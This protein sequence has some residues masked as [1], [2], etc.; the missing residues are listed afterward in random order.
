MALRQVTCTIDGV[1]VTIV[2]DDVAG[3][4]TVS[5]ELDDGFAGDFRG[6]FFKPGVDVGSLTAAGVGVT[7][8]LGDP[9]G[10]QDMGQGANIHGV[11][12]KALEPTFGVEIGGPGNGQGM[13]EA[14]SFVLTSSDGPLTLEDLG[15]QMGIRITGGNAAGKLLCDIPAAP[16]AQDD[17]AYVELADT[18]DI[19]VAAND[20]DADGDLDPTSVAITDPPDFG[21]AVVNPDG[22]VTYADTIVDTAGDDSVVDAFQYQIDDDDGNFGQAD[23]AVNV[24][25]PLREV[26]V[27]DAVTPNGQSISLTVATEDRTANDSSFVEVDIVTGDLVEVDVNVAFVFDASGSISAAEYAEQIEAIQDTIDLLRTQFTGAENDVEVQLIR[28]ATGA[29]ASANFDLFDASLDDISALGI[30]TQTGGFTNYTAALALAN[31][32]FDAV[33]LAGTEDNFVLFVSDGEPTTGGSFLDEAADLQAR[34]SV[35]A[36]GFGGGVNEATLDQV[37]NTGGAEVVPD[38]ESLSDVFAAS[39]LFNAVLVDFDLTLSVDGGAPIVLADDVG[40][41][42]D[43]GGGDYSL[44]LASVGGLCGAESCINVFTAIAVFDTD[45][46]LATDADRITLTGVNTVEGAVP[47]AFWV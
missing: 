36:V 46:N 45:G 13:I 23:V 9:D 40:D 34:A 12:G 17:I 11:V 38:A 4:L 30:T 10:I 32:F 18:V 44:D 24:I 33:D 37:D 15:S 22:T 16:L 29:D 6:F 43:N 39:P 19:D 28:F 35:T 20:S 21:T 31:D 7:E 26:Q 2:E 42:V 25:D 1:I 14:G 3:T 27:D 8:F 5:Y 47:D 41:L